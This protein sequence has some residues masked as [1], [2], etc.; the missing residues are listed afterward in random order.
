M[1]A[2]PSYGLLHIVAIRDQRASVSIGAQVLLDNE[3]G[4]HRVAQF[5]LFETIP[6]RVDGLRVIFHHPQLVLLRN[7]AD[8][9]HV[10]AVPVQMHGND[11]NRPRA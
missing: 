1:I 7:R 2:H 5:A 9:L 6:M 11:S 10:R 8:R 4:A 3:A